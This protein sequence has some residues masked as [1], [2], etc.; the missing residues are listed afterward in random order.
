MLDCNT[1]DSTTSSDGLAGATQERRGER[2][3]K[4]ARARATGEHALLFLSYKLPSWRL[5]V[6]G[7]VGGAACWTVI[8]SKRR[9]RPYRGR[10]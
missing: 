1:L 3:R 5:E 9:T 8:R 2:Q 7:G 6:R 10:A 4:R